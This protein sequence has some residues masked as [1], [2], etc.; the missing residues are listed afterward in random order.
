MSDNLD[1]IKSVPLILEARRVR[2][3]QVVKDSL[4]ELQNRIVVANN[5][6]IFAYRIVYKSK[7]KRVVGYLVEPRKGGDLPCI[8]WNRGGSGDFGMI[9]AEHLFGGYS[10]IGSLA[11]RGYVVVATQYPGVEGGEGTDEMGGEEDVASIL[12]LYKILK[13][14]RRADVTRVGMEGFSRGGMMT[15]LCLARVRWIKAAVV[16]AA[17]SDEVSAPKFRKGWKEHQQQM[18][19]GSLA[20]RKKRSAIY[21]VDRFPRKTPLLV[22]HGAADRRVNPADSLRLGRELCKNKIPFR[23]V[24]FER[25]DHYLTGFGDEYE[26]MVFDWFDRFLKTKGHKGEG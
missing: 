12:D 25:A 4:G 8:I 7:G 22:M 17:P 24:L 1:E 23:L 2:F 6:K 26:R 3:S 21:W 20:E 19:G 15:Y 16:G 10:T 18:Y 13:S 5:R 11:A 14:Y 9:E